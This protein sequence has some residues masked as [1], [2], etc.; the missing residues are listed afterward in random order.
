MSEQNSQSP[1]SADSATPR[2]SVTFLF[3][4]MQAC[5]AAALGEI[6]RRFFPRM[7]GLA[8]QTLS[9]LPHSAADAEDV[10]QSA[11]ISFW[12]AL[13][14]QHNLAFG[15][16]N[17]L[18]NL[19]GVITVRKARRQARRES[20]Q[21]RGGGKTY[22]DS[23]VTGNGQT[24]LLDL[25]LAEISP[26]DFDL[27]CEEMLLVLDEETRAVAILRLQGFSSSEIASRMDC[28]PR[29]IQ[30]ALTTARERWSAFADD[31]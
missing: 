2:G 14:A 29:T 23:G 20:A 9:R 13:E 22:T 4:Q 1:G 17:D 25:A 3:S 26:P 6:W 18:W 28:T 10:A 30:R 11:F 15:D 12:K 19:L 7:A 27:F 31:S 16:R 21:K 5:D 24:S 8:R